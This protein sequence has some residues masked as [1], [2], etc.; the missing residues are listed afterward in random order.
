[1]NGSYD[2][3]VVGGGI[4]GLTAAKFAHKLGK[5]VLIVEKNNLGGQ[6]IWTGCV[7]S[8]ALAHYAHVIHNMNNPT[9]FGLQRPTT[10]LFNQ[11]KV[12]EH[13]RSI[14]CT[15]HQPD[16]PEL[17]REMGM[18]VQTSNAVFIDNNYAQVGDRTVF[19]NKVIIAT[20]SRQEI[21][22]L[23][24]IEKIPYITHATLFNLSTLPTSILILGAGV[25][26]VE[27]A[28]S[29]NRLGVHVI[30]LEMQER[31]LPKEDEEVAIALSAALRQEGALV[32]T[33]MRAHAVKY[34][35]N[36]ITL[37]CTHSDG[38]DYYFQ[39]EH[40]LLA[41]GRIPNTEG[42]YLNRTA[43]EFNEDGF[44]KVNNYL[45]TKVSNMYACGEVIGAPA[46]GS[47]ARYQGYLAAHNAIIPF[48]KKKFIYTDV[49]RVIF[50][51]SEFATVGLTEKVARELY[52]DAIQIHRVNYDELDRAIACKNTFGFAKFIC[53][54]RGFLIGAHIFGQRAGEIINEIQVGKICNIK[55]KNWYHMMQAHPTF[56]ELIWHG[57]QREYNNGFNNSFLVKCVRKLLKF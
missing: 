27:M 23:Q 21:T 57:A 56:S 41:T 43:V 24:G 42:M 33:N 18:H 16:K 45:H 48:F 37:Q 22:A 26:G 51:L 53:D 13:I 9:L 49:P 35:D 50:A 12:L 39:A 7:A 20:G 15:A 8:K 4:A 34:A 40:L 28:S 32:V 54:K 29:L 3:M 55:L 14:I 36:I 46:S 30:L 25:V 1:M 44:L 6:C 17:L 11:E 10:P 52:G 2:L 47:I 38:K 19:A 31:I 5:K